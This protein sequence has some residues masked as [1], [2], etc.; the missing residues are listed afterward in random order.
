MINTDALKTY[1]L[2]ALSMAVSS[3]ASIDDG[4]NAVWTSEAEAAY[5]QC[6][7]DNMAVATAWEMIEQSCRE[8][9]AGSNDRLDG[10]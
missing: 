9:V 2:V 7:Q 10:E 5:Q 6:L 1:F 3:C 4:A 8:R